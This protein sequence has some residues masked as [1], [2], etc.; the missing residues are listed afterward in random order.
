MKTKDQVVIGW[1]DPGECDGMFALTIANVYASR[2]DRIYGLIRV[3]S[4]GLLSRG[5]NELV[6]RFMDTT[7]AEWLLMLDSDMQ[8]DIDTFDKLIGAVHDKTHPIVAGLYFG[9]W[10][11]D[12]YPT[13]MPL[14]FKK[15]DHP[16][17]FLPL[18]D[19]PA[20]TVIPIDSAGTGCLL[21]HRSVFEAFRKEATPHEGQNWCWFRDMPVNGDWFSEDHYF[22]ARSREL[23]F[24]L[25]AHTGATLPHRKQFW[26][27]EKHHRPET[28]RAVPKTEKRG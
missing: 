13:A 10:P 24:Q 19:Y 28:A 17:R 21:V 18:V 4:G 9:A 11:G 16:T 14:I 12:F 27:A 3:E 25:H 7:D 1:M 23:G 5:R 20:N 26:L 22:C 8:I 15:S 2:A 6:A